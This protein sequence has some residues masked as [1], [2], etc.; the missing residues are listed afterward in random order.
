MSSVLTK[1]I[2]DNDNESGKEAQEIYQEEAAPAEPRELEWRLAYSGSETSTEIRDLAPATQYQ[3]RI[4]ASNSAGL[5]DYSC[6]VSMVT[7]AAAPA[8]PRGQGQ[9]ARLGRLRAPRAPAAG[10]PTLRPCASLAARA[11]A[12]A[13]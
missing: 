11:P 9:W 10:R 6:N 13:L 3:L 7:P 2:C 1:P 5:S 12:G 4:A 8:P